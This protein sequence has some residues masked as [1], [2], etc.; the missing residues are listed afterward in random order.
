MTATSNWKVL[1]EIHFRIV[2]I[3]DYQDLRLPAMGN[4]MHPAGKARSLSHLLAKTSKTIFC[5]LFTTRINPKQPP[6]P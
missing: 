2:S 3:V 4:P 1:R 5:I 6:V